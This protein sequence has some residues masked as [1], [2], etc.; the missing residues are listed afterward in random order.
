MTAFL[1][2]ALCEGKGSGLPPWWPLGYAQTIALILTYVAV[3]R[4]DTA[5]RQGE[6]G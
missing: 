5:P 1:S 4:Y 6:G 2:K 3:A